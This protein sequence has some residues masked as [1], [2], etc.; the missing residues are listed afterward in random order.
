M[1]TSWLPAIQDLKLQDLKTYDVG[2]LKPGTPYSRRYPEQAPVDGERIPTLR[3]VIRL[4]KK[5]CDTA[6][7][8]WIEIK[9]TPGKSDLTP[10]PET[11]SVNEMPH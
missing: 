11:V 5:K 9:T 4:Y 7:Q 3:E 1:P 6:T 2:R 10:A 8:L